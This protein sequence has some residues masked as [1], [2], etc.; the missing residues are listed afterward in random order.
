MSVVQSDIADVND[1]QQRGLA[2]V[3]PG[4]RAWLITVTDPAGGRVDDLETGKPRV[5][6]WLAASRRERTYKSAH[7]RAE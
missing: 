6:V 5:A 2:I 1:I 7:T 4:Y 3:Q